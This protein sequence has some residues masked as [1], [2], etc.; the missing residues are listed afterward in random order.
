MNGTFQPMFVTVIFFYQHLQLLYDQTPKEIQNLEFVQGVNFDFI[1][2]LENNGTKNLLFFDD[3]Y[4]EICAS[5]VFEKIAV[6]GRHRGLS[7]IYIKH[8]LFQKSKLSGDI[9]LQNANIA[10]LKSPRDVLQVVRLSV[11]LGLCSSLVN[12]YKDASSALF[13]HLLIDLSPRIDDQLRYS[14]NCG[15]N[16]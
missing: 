10:L 6:S 11:Q 14:T 1:D 3:S 13:G 9:E 7:T 12:W 4:Q 16:L 5:R 15:K 2:S 8:N